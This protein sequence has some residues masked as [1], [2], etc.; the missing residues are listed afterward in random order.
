MPSMP[1]GLSP[2]GGTQPDTGLAVLTH[3]LAIFTGF[4]GP[5]IVYLVKDNDPFVRHHAAE[6]LNFSIATTIAYIVSGVLIIVLIGLILLPIVWI[7]ALVF[8]IQAAIAANRGEWYR[9]P[10]S[11]RLVPGAVG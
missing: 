5:L 10:L 9:Y 7:G 11:I 2:T 4:I 6:A 3:I 8:Q 1:H